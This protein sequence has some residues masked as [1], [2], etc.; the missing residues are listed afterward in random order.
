MIALWTHHTGVPNY[1][2][3]YRLVA[4]AADRVWRDTTNRPLRI[5][6]SYNNVLYGTLFYFPERPTTY[7]IVSPYLTPWVDAARIAR[8]GILIYCPAAE[9]ICMKPLDEWAARSPQARRQEV[10]I[11]RDFLGI[12]R[13]TD[14]VRDSRDSASSGKSVAGIIVGD[15]RDR[16][17]GEEHNPNLAVI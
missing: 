16:R 11:S 13:T 9:V 5:V 3:Q 10:T 4:E 14:A 8:D 15:C 2:D 1:G 17:R 6:G 7:E 12:P